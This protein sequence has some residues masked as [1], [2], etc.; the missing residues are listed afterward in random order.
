MA[1]ILVLDYGVPQIPGCEACK[2]LHRDRQQMGS[3]ANVD[4]IPRFRLLEQ[5]RTEPSG[6]IMR[7][8]FEV[9]YVP[10]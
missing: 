4:V 8:D 10:V 1:V 2:E 3:V 6:I 5:I 7:L 9:Q